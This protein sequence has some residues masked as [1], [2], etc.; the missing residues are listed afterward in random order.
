MRLDAVIF[1]GG[2]AGLWLLDRLSRDGHHVVLLESR[3]L[4]AG[5][6]VGSQAILHVGRTSAAN[7]LASRAAKPLRELP[8]LWR[9][10]LLGRI[11]P[12]LTRT[13]LRSECCYLWQAESPGPHVVTAGSRLAA[14]SDSEALADEE[15]PAALAEVA[16]PVC[17][18]PEQVICPASFLADLADQ[19]RDRLLLIDAERGLRFRLNSPGEVDAIQL[20]SPSD[21]STLELKPRQ[22]IFTAGSDNA[23][24]RE[25]VGLSV[26]AL[27]TRPLHMVLAR[28][29][30]PELNGHCVEA[31]KTIVTVTSDIDDDGRTVWQIGGVLAE[32]GFKL[33][34]HAQTERV[35]EELIRILPRL[36]LRQI[37]W[38]TYGL[39]RAEGELSNNSRR[40]VVQVF[41]AGNVTTG[42]PTRL[43]LAPVLAAEI[44]D[45]AS[46]P[47]ITAPFDSTP[48]ADWPR[49][50]TASV[51][52]NEADRDWWTLA[53]SPA[54]QQP[55]RRA[56]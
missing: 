12:N 49:P 22:V 47:Y 16:G 1:G 51:P 15:R 8:N 25:L 27:P 32:H 53:D 55:Q 14:R 10:A 37:E 11:A 29:N 28:G 6:T 46:S 31:A 20:T 41:C 24:L 2:A 3:G 43:V 13:R 36:D 5:D 26:D 21:G 34:P 38:S 39:D 50:E 45:R 40:E 19:Y 17:R 35:R 48:L 7:G 9:D 44:A 54:R 33:E 18:L 23:R 52:W 42:C 4:G 30:L 56:A